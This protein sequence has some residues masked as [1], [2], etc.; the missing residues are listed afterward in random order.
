MLNSKDENIHILTYG[1]VNLHHYV[2]KNAPLGK[3][4]KSTIPLYFLCALEPGVKNLRRH[5]GN[6]WAFCSFLCLCQGKLSYI[7]SG[8]TH[9]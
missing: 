5:C 1:F 7:T 9:W 2:D 6:S 8:I 3:R 4:S